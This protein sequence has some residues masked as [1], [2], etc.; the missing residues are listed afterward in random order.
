MDTT[1]KTRIIKDF[2]EK[3]IIVTREFISPVDA[4]WKA[5]TESETLDRWWGPSPWRA[6]TKKMDFSAGGYWHYAM[7]GPDGERHWGRMNYL[8]IEPGKRIEIE[9]AFCDENGAQS[10]DLPV[11]KGELTFKKTEKGAEVM[12][13]M[14]YPDEADLHKLVEMGFEEGI[15]ICFDQLEALPGK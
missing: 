1:G 15:T 5:F 7:V 10:K 13:K 12:F 11:A 14:V 9:D 6:E 3:S 8:T 4:L 2:K